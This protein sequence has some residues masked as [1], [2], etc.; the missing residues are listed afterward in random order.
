VTKVE[1]GRDKVTEKILLEAGP[2]AAKF[3]IE[4]VDIRIKRIN[5][6][7]QVQES[8]YQRMIVERQR[9]AAK[10]RS[11]GEG[12]RRGD[13]DLCRGLFEGSGVLFVSGDAQEL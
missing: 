1:I 11:E 3:G 6:V 8:V 12:E 10:F 9:I 2:A 4:L 13:Q 5:Y 7:T